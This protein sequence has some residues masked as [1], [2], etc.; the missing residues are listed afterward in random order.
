MCAF[1]KQ[2]MKKI[3][4]FLTGLT[5]L[6]S[7]FTGCK[8]DDEVKL[9]D[10]TI[11]L[12]GIGVS[13]DVTKETG[14]VIRFKILV[15]KGA[16]G[17]N[18]DMF[19]SK[20]TSSLTG[21]PF[22]STHTK[23]NNASFPLDTLIT[24][25]SAAQTIDY[26]FTATTTDGKTATR[27]IKVTVNLPSGPVAP[28]SFSSVTFSNDNGFLAT[29]VASATQGTDSSIAKGNSSNVDITYFYSSSTTFH[30]FISPLTRKGTNYQ[31]TAAYQSW[32]AVQTIWKTTTLTATDFD[33]VDDQTTLA[34]HFTNGT[35][36]VYPS[37]TDGERIGGNDFAVGKVFAFK[38]ASSGKYG[39]VKIVGVTSGGGATV[40]IKVEN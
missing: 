4:A 13:A 36:A 25:P 28:K 29:S 11:T 27:K 33:A 18:I 30:S 26:E 34:G 16:D 5:L 7:V 2:K 40:A 19:V 9:E 21:T 10:P 15:N 35:L 14:E 37:N 12:D 8:K 20:S 38:N 3:S 23:I 6:A 17:K 32:G 1:I 22:T 31:G 24:L 39:L